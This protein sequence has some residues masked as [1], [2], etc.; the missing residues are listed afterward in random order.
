MFRLKEDIQRL[1]VVISL[2]QDSEY[3]IVEIKSASDFSTLHTSVKDMLG[4]GKQYWD[5]LRGASGFE[6]VQQ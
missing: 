4:I 5:K 6:P 1:D 2:S 3:L